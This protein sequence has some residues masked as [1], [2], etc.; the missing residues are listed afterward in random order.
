MLVSS[1]N[2]NQKSFEYPKDW[3]QGDRGIWV[4]GG[5]SPSILDDM[6]YISISTPA[7]TVIFGTIAAN[8]TGNAGTSG[9]GRGIWAGGYGY[10]LSTDDITYITIATPGNS[11][12]FGDLTGTRWQPAAVSNGTRA[13]VMGRRQGTADAKT[14]D[15]ITIA[16]T[17]NASSFGH[18]YG[19]TLEDGAD[20]CGNGTYGMTIYNNSG[21]GAEK[22]EYINLSSLGDAYHFGNPIAVGIGCAAVSNRT[23]AIWAGGWF[24]DSSR[25]NIEYY[26]W[27]ALSNAT[28]YGNLGASSQAYYARGCNSSTRGVVGGGSMSGSR[29]HINYFSLDLTPGNAVISTGNINMQLTYET[30]RYNPGCMSGD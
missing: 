12:T 27:T 7:S 13:L 5:D 8:S 26:T 24:N 6:E 2:L 20:A 4:G 18:M 16:T 22:F 29:G 10:N 3:G 30:N 1:S 25:A 15:Y 17:G 28:Q 19:N 23:R 11:S 9:R 21:Q 14:I